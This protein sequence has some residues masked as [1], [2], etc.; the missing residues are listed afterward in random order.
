L[1]HPPRTAYV[2]AGPHR[3]GTS[4][5]AGLLGNSVGVLPTDLMRPALSNAKGFNES[6][7]IVHFNES[8]FREIGLTWDSIEPTGKQIL[9]ESF[10]KRFYSNCLDCLRANFP[11]SAKNESESIVLKD[12]RFCR[13][14]PIWKKALLDLRYEIKVV[15]PLRSPVDVMHSLMKRDE[16]DSASAVLIWYWHIVEILIHTEGMDISFIFYDQLLDNPP[17]HMRMSL[18]IEISDSVASIIDRKLNHS[19]NSESPTQTFLEDEPFHASM[20]LYE[21]LLNSSSPDSQ[22]V[23]AVK[24]SYFFNHVLKSNI[25]RKSTA[26]HKRLIREISILNGLPVRENE[27]RFKSV[28]SLDHSISSDSSEIEEKRS[29][30]TSK[31]YKLWNLFKNP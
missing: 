8:I 21:N 23:L 17:E 6:W 12:P 10:K 19:K 22:M 4:L 26:L 7:S 3:S 5:V 18:N 27:K 15:I 13:T 28:N 24:S 25:E 20:M 9:K 30:N 1:N 29:K 11:E 31:F 14:F 2:V 16:I